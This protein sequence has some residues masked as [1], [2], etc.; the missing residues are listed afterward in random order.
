MTPWFIAIKSLTVHPFRSTQK[1]IFKRS[2]NDSSG[3]HNNARLSNLNR[4]QFSLAGQTQKSSQPFKFAYWEG[5]K[6]YALPFSRQ[7]EKLWRSKLVPDE[8]L[9]LI[10]LLWSSCSGKAAQS[11]A[12]PTAWQWSDNDLPH[13]TSMALKS[14]RGARKFV[15]C[16]SG[17]RLL[18]D[19][20]FDS[21][22]Q[23]T[24]I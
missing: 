9:R 14:S 8:L 10:P 6:A 13:R 20:F 3:D 4:H 23:P 19:F 15:N 24:R 21:F 2:P 17:N 1:K 11:D 18:H 12:R 16:C 7:W 5:H 22:N